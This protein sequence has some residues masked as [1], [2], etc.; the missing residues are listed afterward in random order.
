MQIIQAKP[1]QNTINPVSQKGKMDFFGVKIGIH[2]R[3]KTFGDGVIRKF[4]NSSI[5]VS[6]GSAEK[7]FPF[8]QAF[9]DGFLIQ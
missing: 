1:L 9:E 3:H 8:P 6:F 4:D 7:K 2:V 5:V